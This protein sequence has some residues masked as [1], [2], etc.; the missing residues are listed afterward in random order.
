[1]AGRVGIFVLRNRQSEWADWLSQLRDILG[2]IGDRVGDG[3]QQGYEPRGH[4]QTRVDG[5]GRIS[6]PEGVAPTDVSAAIREYWPREL[7]GDAARV[8]YHESNGWNAE[9]MRSTLDRAGGACN[10]FLG[11]LDDGSAYYSEESVGI[12]QINR[13]S[14]GGSREDWYDINHNVRKAWELY[15]DSGD[16]SPWIYTASHLGLMGD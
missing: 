5:S 2:A 7:W 1:M 11:Y 12:F 15:R 6:V 14:H 3:E 4:Y 13:C 9:A 8:A 10:V 16:W